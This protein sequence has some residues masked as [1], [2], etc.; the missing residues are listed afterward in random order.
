[1]GGGKFGGYGFVVL[2]SHQAVEKVIKSFG[3]GENFSE[4][5]E[6]EEEEEED[7]EKMMDELDQSILL[8]DVQ[9]ELNSVEFLEAG[10]DAFA[11][12]L[13][14]KLDGV[15]FMIEEE[16]GKEG[17]KIEKGRKEGEQIEMEVAG[18]EP[19]VKLRAWTL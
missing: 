6:K 8:F 19:V 2:D 9:N 14:K 3:A 17:E 11:G 1:M 10:D 16:G 4:R 18:E 13:E 5:Q 7:I 12:V 15:Q